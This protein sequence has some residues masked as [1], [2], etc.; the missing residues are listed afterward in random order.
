MALAVVSAIAMLGGLQHVVPA[1]LRTS[2]LLLEVSWREWLAGSDKPRCGRRG[3]H[4]ARSHFAFAAGIVGS[5][6]G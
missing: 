4:C 1:M 2:L 3:T 5:V 6:A